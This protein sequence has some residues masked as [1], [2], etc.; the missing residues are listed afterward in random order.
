MTDNCA[1]WV[2]LTDVAPLLN[3][4]PATPQAHFD[5]GAALRSAA[6]LHQVKHVFLYSVTPEHALLRFSEMYSI[7]PLDDG[8]TSSMKALMRKA[9]Q[10]LVVEHSGLQRTT[11]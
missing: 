6:R 1:A 3:P 10:V 7:H 9:C 8:F 11:L 4:V 5:E 2:L